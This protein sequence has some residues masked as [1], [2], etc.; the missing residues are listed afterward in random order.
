MHTGIINTYEPFD[1]V[2]YYLLSLH[3]KQILMA[4]S[5]LNTEL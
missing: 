3:W 1:N 5:T 4:F 2:F